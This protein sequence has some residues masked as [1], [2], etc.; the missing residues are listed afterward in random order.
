MRRRMLAPVHVDRDAEELR[1]LGQ[2]AGALQPPCPLLKITRPL[3]PWI[4]PAPLHGSWRP[5]GEAIAPERNVGPRSRR[6]YVDEG[7]HEDPSQSAPRQRTYGSSDDVQ[8]GATA[9]CPKCGIDSVIPLEPGMDVAFLRRT[10]AHW[11]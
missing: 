1:D 11:F 8:A 9:L 3:R 10:K 6:L 2:L 4:G 5:A 7:G